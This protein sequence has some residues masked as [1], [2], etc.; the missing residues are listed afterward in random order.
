MLNSFRPQLGPLPVWP[1]REASPPPQ[2]IDPSLLL[3]RHETPTP[4]PVASEPRL[5]RKRRSDEN[6]PPPP[7]A[8]RSRMTQDIANSIAV[9]ATTLDK[10]PVC[11]HDFTQL[12]PRQAKAHFLKYHY[13][14]GDKKR[15]G[16]K[17]CKWTGC[18]YSHE[19]WNQVLRHM[20]ADHFIPRHKCHECGSTFARADAWTRHKD[21][22]CVSP[23]SFFL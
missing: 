7:K 5:R 23:V 6:S 8:R 2:T 13:T 11:S 14:K 21:G 20:D 16:K 3:L 15:V 4:T 1:R 22:A 17:K 10:C 18:R 19:S 12:E 9:K